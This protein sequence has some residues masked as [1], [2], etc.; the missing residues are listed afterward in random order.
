MLLF[1]VMAALL[2]VAGVAAAYGPG[3]DPAYD[4][5]RASPCRASAS[6]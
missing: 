5:G 3:V 2:P 1:L 6:C 4:V